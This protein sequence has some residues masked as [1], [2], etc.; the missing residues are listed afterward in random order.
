MYYNK[1]KNILKIYIAIYWECVSDANQFQKN[2]FDFVK[3]SNDHHDYSFSTHALS[4]IHPSITHICIA[5][6]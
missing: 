6:L 3:D 2:Y 1:I 4:N 5:S